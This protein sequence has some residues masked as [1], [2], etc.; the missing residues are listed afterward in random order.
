MAPAITPREYEAMLTRSDKSMTNVVHAGEV[1]INSAPTRSK[2]YISRHH[3]PCSSPSCGT[4]ITPCYYPCQQAAPLFATRHALLRSTT[5]IVEWHRY[6]RELEN[7]GE[8]F[9]IIES[10]RGAVVCVMVV[11]MME[12]RKRRLL[13]GEQGEDDKNEDGRHL[14]S[15]RSRSF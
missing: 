7:N 9:S 2:G 15:F 8:N 4:T 11:S 1:M 10:P 6:K 12:V 14:L 3:P 5:K 13:R